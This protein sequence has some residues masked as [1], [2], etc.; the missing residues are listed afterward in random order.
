MKFISLPNGTLI[1]LEQ[2]AY[3]ST[4]GR[5]PGKSDSARPV[6]V[7]GSV[8]IHFAVPRP[9]DH[10]QGWAEPHMKLKLNGEIAQSFLVQLGKVGVDVGMLSKARSA[11]RKDLQNENYKPNYMG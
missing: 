8:V 2:I 1:N 7:D 11:D 9:V 5:E 10:K 4:D 3:I 6:Y